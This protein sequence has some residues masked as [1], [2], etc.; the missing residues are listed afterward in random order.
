VSSAPGRQF[1][2]ASMNYTPDLSVKRP[3]NGHLQIV[4]QCW[5]E[6]AK[7]DSI[8]VGRESGRRLATSVE[9]VQAS[10]LVFENRRDLGLQM[11]DVK[12]IRRSTL[13][14]RSPRLSS[15]SHAAVIGRT[16]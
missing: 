4:R 5:T 15:G 10:P 6:D 16:R 12:N 7:A 13:N 8:I 11:I 9:L 3:M 14:A 1:S 2:P